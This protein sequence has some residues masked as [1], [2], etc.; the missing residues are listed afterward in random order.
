MHVKFAI[1][2]K[3]QPFSVHPQTL[4]CD[5]TVF[6]FFFQR[7]GMFST[8]IIASRPQTPDLPNPLSSRAL[9]FTTPHHTT[10]R[11][12]HQ[13]KPRA[14]STALLADL[15]SPNAQPGH[16]KLGPTD[17]R[18]STVSAGW[19]LR[20]SRAGQL[21]SNQPALCKLWYLVWRAGVGASQA[22]PAAGWL[23]GV[24]MATA[25]LFSQSACISLYI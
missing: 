14:L 6:S 22:A 9:S 15:Q 24:A 11:F 20:G 8:I 4:F 19:G 2:N 21:T 25:I 17:Q 16:R 13:A 10:T 3:S 1:S 5:Y 23:P 18:A 7:K 12:H